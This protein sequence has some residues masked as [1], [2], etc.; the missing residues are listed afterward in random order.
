METPNSLSPATAE[1]MMNAASAIKMVEAMFESRLKTV[2]R[3]LFLG[4]DAGASWLSDLGMLVAE[5]GGFAAEIDPG[6]RN[7]TGGGVAAGVAGWENDGAG[8]AG[9][10]AAIVGWMNG[11][12]AGSAKPG[13]CMNGARQTAC[14]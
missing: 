5:F 11:I 2:L 13:D 10:L 9:A 3:M 7:G 12:A 14:H 6:C 4:R 1:K 8:A